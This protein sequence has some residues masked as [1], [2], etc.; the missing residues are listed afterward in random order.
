MVFIPV[1]DCIPVFPFELVS[2]CQYFGFFRSRPL[3]EEKEEQKPRRGRMLA[4]EMLDMKKCYKLIIR[5][6]NVVVE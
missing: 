1:W 4:I 3:C 6:K 2:D 5:L